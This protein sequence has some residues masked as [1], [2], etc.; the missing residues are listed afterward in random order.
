MPATFLILNELRPV[1]L[2]ITQG[3]FV[4]EREDPCIDFTF[5]FNRSKMTS[6]AWPPSDGSR[7]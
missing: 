1:I 5:T 2:N 4:S 6:I 3:F 7:T